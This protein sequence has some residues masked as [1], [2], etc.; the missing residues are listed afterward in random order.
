MA[1]ASERGPAP[2]L[3]CAQSLFVLNDAR[4][5]FVKAPA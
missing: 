2:L 5:R 4:L 1:L 3:N